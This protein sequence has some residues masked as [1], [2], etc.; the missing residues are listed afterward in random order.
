MNRCYDCVFFNQ[1]EF[2][3]NINFCDDCRKYG[4]CLITNVVCLM[5]DEIEYDNCFE[6]RE[7]LADDM[8]VEFDSH[9]SYRV[10]SKVDNQMFELTFDNLSYMSYDK[11]ENYNIVLVVYNK[12]KDSMRNL[13]NT[14]L[15]GRNPLVMVIKIRKAFELIEQ[16]LLEDC[17]TFNREC[18]VTCYWTDNH[19][20]NAY[21][22]F[23]QP[24]GYKIGK[25]DGKK[26]LYKIYK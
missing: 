4:D 21:M 26:C 3:N 14:D 13:V 23:L 1:C 15:T 19:R 7:E 17:K 8:F 2:A 25:I 6:P 12:R 16:E 20:R 10:K 24:K 11:R 9:L 5:G 22:K 18:L